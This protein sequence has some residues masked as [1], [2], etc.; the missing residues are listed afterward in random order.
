MANEKKAIDQIWKDSDKL[1]LTVSLKSRAGRSFKEKGVRIYR[2]NLGYFVPDYRNISKVGSELE[3]EG[4]S[5]LAESR[6]G[7]SILGEKGLIKEFFGADIKVKTASVPFGKKKH[8]IRMPEAQLIIP[9]AFSKTIDRVKFE[10]YPIPLESATPPDVDY[11]HLDVPDDIANILG[12][13]GLHPCGYDGSGVKV[14]MIDDGFFEHAYYTTM[15]YDITLVPVAGAAMPEGKGHGTAI[16]SNVLAVAPGVEFVFVNN[17]VW[18]FSIATAAFRVAKDENPD[19][20]TCSWGLSS[21]DEDLAWEIADAVNNG[22]TVVFACGNEGPIY[23]PGCMDDVISVGGVFPEEG[24]GF[25]ASTYASSG[26]CAD[27]PGRQ[28]PDVS[29]LVGD[30]DH[31]VLIMMPTVPDGVYDGVFDDYD[32]TTAD[33]GWLCGS[34]TSSAAPQVAGTAALMLQC[35]PSLTPDQ[36][37]TILSNTATDIT[38]GNSAS[39]EPAGP[40]LDLATG[41]GLI[42]AVAAMETLGC[43][44]GTPCLGYCETD[45]MPIHEVHGCLAACETHG[46]M[47]ISEAHGCLAVCDIHGCMTICEGHGCMTICATHGCLTHC[48]NHAC[49]VACQTVYMTDCRVLCETG[50]VLCTPAVMAECRGSAMVEPGGCGPVSLIALDDYTRIKIQDILK[51]PKITTEVREHLE[52]LLQ[53]PQQGIHTRKLTRTGGGQAAYA[54]KMT[55][56]SGIKT[57]PRTPGVKRRARRLTMRG[58]RGGVRT[59][60]RPGYGRSGRDKCGCELDCETVCVLCEGACTVSCQA[61]CE[62]DCQTSCQNECMASWEADCASACESHNIVSCENS[63]M[64]AWEGMSCRTVCESDSIVAC[65]FKCELLCETYYQG[66]VPA[67]MTGC[68]PKIEGLVEDCAIHAFNPYELEEIYGII[69]NPATAQEVKARLNELI[70]THTRGVHTRRLT[71]VERERMHRGQEIGWWPPPIPCILCDTTCMSDCELNCTVGCEVSC[72]AYCETVDMP[73]TCRVGRLV[74]DMTGRFTACSASLEVGHIPIDRYTINEVRGLL[75]DPRVNR[76]IKE[77]L[78]SLLKGNR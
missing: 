5:V 69:Q 15:G 73:I 29:G 33:D 40:G 46:C 60:P 21:Y 37:K 35:D 64:V 48:E 18:I 28:C 26:E 10:Q 14:C 4:F 67:I 55:R 77:R 41:A 63:C 61:D 20:I 45:C 16:A 50:H 56:K 74:D 62:I 75:N 12:A 27:N 49:T 78:L 24:G 32:N 47:T 54:R 30:A 2:G 42:N 39:G 36:I 70:Q 1:G 8:K 51:D 9:E 23:F 3:R 57:E 22:I 71:A 6:L 44:C 38:V 59:Q 17:M 7:L 43:T 66:C 76:A 31:G 72:T 65:K 53:P 52:G 34:G 58:R 25:H 11:Y 13:S 68:I 19:I